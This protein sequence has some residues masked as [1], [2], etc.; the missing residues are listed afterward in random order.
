MDTISQNCSLHLIENVNMLRDKASMSF[1]DSS[2][3]MLPPAEAI[4]IISKIPNK[5]PLGW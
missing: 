4:V 3:E 5:V 2:S 1:S